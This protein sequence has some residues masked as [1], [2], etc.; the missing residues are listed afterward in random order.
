MGTCTGKPQNVFR[1]RKIR[2]LDLPESPDKLLFGTYVHVCMKLLLLQDSRRFMGRQLE[3]INL[4]VP[5]LTLH[6]R[7]GCQAC[8]SWNCH[9]VY[10][11]NATIIRH[12]L[13]N[14]FGVNYIHFICRLEGIHDKCMDLELKPTLI[15]AQ[16][17]SSLLASYPYVATQIY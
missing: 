13:S 9:V 15:Y 5:S 6:G 7:W 3:I 17:K 16:H 14:C 2:A 4:Y 10:R 8:C 11:R 1:Q 12:I